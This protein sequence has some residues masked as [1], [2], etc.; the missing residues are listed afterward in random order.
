[1]TRAVRGS[2][3]AVGRGASQPPTRARLA[4]I[5]PLL[6]AWPA[7]AADLETQHAL[8]VALPVK[9][10]LELILHTR[11]RT[12]PGGLGFYQGRVGPVLN[13]A[14]SRRID[15]LAGYYYARQQRKADRDFVA[16]HRFF[17]G[18]EVAAAS[19]RRLSF[20]QRALAERFQSDAAP[21]FSRYRFR[22]RFSV[23]APVS[24]YTGHEFFLDSRGWRST[25][26]S[27]GI[28]WSP[29]PGVQIDLGYLFENRRADLGGDRHLWLTSLHFRK[30]PRRADPDM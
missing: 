1:M 26:H 16:G 21:D 10:K 18:A 4:L 17:G 27:A 13:W 15:L 25:R 9:P 23:Q 30:S 7:D 14:A 3:P 8:D 22:G 28:R 6:L 29:I 5:L 20:D 19:Y 2:L 11:I 12:Q 24:P